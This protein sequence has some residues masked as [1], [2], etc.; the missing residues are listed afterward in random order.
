MLSF[1]ETLWPETF[2][3]ET[4]WADTVILTYITHYLLL[5]KTRPGTRIF[6]ADRN[7]IADYI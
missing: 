2:W 1:L 3:A 4:F 7:L 6:S 5:I